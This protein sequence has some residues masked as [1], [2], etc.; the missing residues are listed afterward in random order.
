VRLAKVYVTNI[1]LP[2]ESGEHLRQRIDLALLNFLRCTVTAYFAILADTIE[3][4]SGGSGVV[5]LMNSV[6]LRCTW[7]L[8]DGVEFGIFGFAS[9]R[10]AQGGLAKDVSDWVR[11]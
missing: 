10:L 7:P 4:G 6:L 1:T 2:P 11:V 8:A 5:T 3:I 9:T